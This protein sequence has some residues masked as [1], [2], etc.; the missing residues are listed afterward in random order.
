MDGRVTMIR[1][2]DDGVASSGSGVV[3]SFPSGWRR[4]SSGVE[5]VQGTVIDGDRG[6][7]SAEYHDEIEDASVSPR[8]NG[9]LGGWFGESVSVFDRVLVRGGV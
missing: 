2:A 5:G 9:C 6:S 1:G 7:L 8:L 3:F 4:V